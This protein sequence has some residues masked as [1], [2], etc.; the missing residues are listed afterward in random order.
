MYFNGADFGGGKP[1]YSDRSGCR[2]HWGG[3]QHPTQALFS[4]NVCKNKEIGPVR[5]RGW[6]QGRPLDPPMKSKKIKKI[7]LILI[8]FWD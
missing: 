5:G 6:R 4:E 3:R 8:H 2:P 1:K 7:L